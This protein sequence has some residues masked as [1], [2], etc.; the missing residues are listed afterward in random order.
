MSGKFRSA[1]LLCHPWPHVKRMQNYLAEAG[2]F[3]WITL[4]AAITGLF[5]SLLFLHWTCPQLATD[6]SS[7]LSALRDG[8]K[9][10]LP[11]AFPSTTHSRS[12]EEV[13]RSVLQK[14]VE[15][16]NT[17]RRESFRLGLG[18]VSGTNTFAYC[19]AS[20]LTDRSQS[21]KAFIGH[22]RGRMNHVSMLGNLL[23]CGS[24]YAGNLH[25]EWRRAASTQNCKQRLE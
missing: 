14:S 4:T 13:Q 16:N 21:Y 1:K 23:I 25:G 11:E 3:L 17:Y 5:S 7:A 22:R 20:I 19:D 8:M 10:G 18:R 9:I 15:L 2:N 24:I 12:N 6:I